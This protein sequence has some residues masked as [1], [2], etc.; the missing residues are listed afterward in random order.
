MQRILFHTDMKVCLLQILR[1][2]K[3]HSAFVLRTERQFA[4]LRFPLRNKPGSDC[5]ATPCNRHNHLDEWVY[6][7]SERLDAIRQTIE[8]LR[9]PCLIDF[10]L[11]FTVR[12]LQ[13]VGCKCL[14]I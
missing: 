5:V 1:E 10:L 13:A 6:R 11:S 4:L 12:G 7:G 9:F 8:V 2:G 3:P 14:S